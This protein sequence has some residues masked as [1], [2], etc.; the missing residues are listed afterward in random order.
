MEITTLITARPNSS[1]LPDKHNRMIGDRTLMDWVISRVTP[2]SDNVVICTTHG[3]IDN[4]KSYVFDPD[5]RLHI[6]A[7]DMDEDNVAGRV[8]HTRHCFPKTNYFVIISG[9]CPLASTK[10]IE[11]MIQ[12]LDHSDGDYV[13]VPGYHNH[14]GIEVMTPETLSKLDDGEH[15]SVA[16]NKFKSVEVSPI[17]DDLPIKV[18]VDNHADLE[19]MRECWSVLGEFNYSLVCELIKHGSNIYK[20]NEHS[21]Q[22]PVGWESKNNVV[23]KTY[24]D[25]NYGMGHVARSIALAQYYNECEHRSVQI[26]VNNHPSVHKIMNRYGYE[27]NLDYFDST[28][29]PVIEED[30]FHTYDFYEDTPLKMTMDW[31]RI[32]K[33][34]PTFAVSPRLNYIPYTF[35]HNR[36]AAMGL[37]NHQNYI[38]KLGKVDIVKPTDTFWYHM[39]GAKT[40]V[41]IKSL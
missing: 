17:Y 5:H 20:L 39:A 2:I 28:T 10:L 27:F 11:D 35:E 26:Y 18:S 15:I 6:H 12:T 19:F 3:N 4:Y 30:K 32:Y 29:L 24:G 21:I 7:P 14:E 22:K 23:I 33:E 9:D 41:G 36:L 25:D 31:E 8:R 1:R 38:K 34:D 40:V 13:T 37:G 16:L